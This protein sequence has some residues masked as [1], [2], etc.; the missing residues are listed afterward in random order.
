MSGLTP[1]EKFAV[2]MTK[3][4]EDEFLLSISPATRVIGHSRKSAPL[5]RPSAL[6]WV[7]K[8]GEELPPDARQGD[9]RRKAESSPSIQSETVDSATLQDPGKRDRRA[10]SFYH[11]RL[12]QPA[13]DIGSRPKPI[14][15]CSRGR[16]RADSPRIKRAFRA[17]CFMAVNCGERTGTETG[18]SSRPDHPWRRV[19]PGPAFGCRSRLPI[20]RPA[21]CRDHR[22]RWRP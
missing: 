4:K 9:G 1:K 21:A 18:L 12:G 13:C 14:E 11:G 17:H 22:E 3:A 7:R 2:E 19:L 20:G 6:S 16:L 5:D 10:S 8:T 15:A